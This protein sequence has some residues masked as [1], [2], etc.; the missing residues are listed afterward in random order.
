[1]VVRMKDIPLEKRIIFALDVSS[2]EEAKRWVDRLIPYI[3]FYKVGLE[4]FLACGFSIVEWIRERGCE[5][6]LDLKLFDIP[7]TVKGAISQIKGKGVTYTTVHGNDGILQAAAEAKGDL[8]VLAVTVLTSLDEGDLKEL[9]FHCSVEDLVLSRAK[10]A[11]ELG[12]DGVVA[13]GRELK[14]IRREI[15]EGLIVV[16]PGIRPVEN[17]EVDDQKRTI[18]VK[19]AFLW[20]ADHVVVGR[21]LRASPEPEKTAQRMLEEVK[22]VLGI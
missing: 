3:K 18:T 22:E 21:P 9:G 8:K 7:A 6:M 16:V 19:E 20:G 5:V 11:L 15:G 10:R 1:M 12:C 13:S 4:L 2:F 17:R 14:A